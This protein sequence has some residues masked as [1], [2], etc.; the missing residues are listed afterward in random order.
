MNGFVILAI[1]AFCLAAIPCGLF[2]SNLLVYRPLKRRRA[3]AA[4]GPLPAVSVLIPARNEEDSIREAVESVLANRGMPL[5]VLV[6]DDHSSDG[7]ARIVRELAAADSRV[8]LVTGERLPPG[9]CGK[10]FACHTLALR[11]SHPLLVFIDADVRLSPDALERM[12]DFIGSRPAALA[13]G[14]PRQLTGTFLEKLLIPLIHFVLL[15]FLP[16][17]L[18]RRGS[19][20]K[21]AAGCGQLFIARREAYFG[22]G[23]HSAIRA[24]LHDGL[25]L[26]R[27]FRR[28][29]FGTDLF[30]ATDVASC[31]MYRTGAETWRG[32][33]KNATE[34][35]AAPGVLPIMTLMM[36]GGQLLPFILLAALPWL[37]SKAAAPA[38]AGA[39]C[40]LLPRL[41]A[42]LLYRQSIL[43]A[44]LHP[45]G[46]L[47]LL[48]IQ[49]QSRFRQLSGM[50]MT[51][52]GR[53]YPANQAREGS[54]APGRLARPVASV[55]LGGLIFAGASLAGASAVSAELPL[56]SSPS[57]ELEDQFRAR[58]SYTFPRARA[59]VLVIADRE[60][61]VQIA[62][63]LRNFKHGRAGDL[64]YAGIADLRKVPAALRG[65]VRSRF[66]EQF[67]Y[68]VMLDWSGSVCAELDIT[69]GQANVLVLDSKGRLAGRVTGPPSTAKVEAA[70]KA[71]ER[72]V[73]SGLPGDAG[74]PLTGTERP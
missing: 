52:R 18:M 27:A 20:P 7:T 42:A 22:A 21:Y 9:W 73:A 3:R 55:I 53:D 26:P 16:M 68:P 65:L 72:A 10:Q 64:E 14:V 6:L 45:A 13:S 11:A 5:E 28:A 46:V 59:V 30:D 31:R 23:G 33:G 43:G 32:L 29:G 36:L 50:P 34:G 58:H 35:L 71:I 37:P 63:W 74:R 8:R 70:S 60:G 48:V 39:I 62:G 56:P 19:K 54:P 12:A 25:Q 17:R 49:W 67:D 69:S 40:A 2:L 4:T 1:A 38:V 41:I 15:G 44:L 51:W 24:S 66:R 57:F 47:L 61:S